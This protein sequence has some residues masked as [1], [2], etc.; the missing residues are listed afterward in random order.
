MASI[1]SSKTAGSSSP[2]TTAPQESRRQYINKSPQGANSKR[3]STLIRIIRLESLEWGSDI[4]IHIKHYVFLTLYNWTKAK[5]PTVL[6]LVN[7]SSYLLTYKVDTYKYSGTPALWIAPT[8]PV[9]IPKDNG[10]T[11][12]NQNSN[13]V[14]ALSFAPFFVALRII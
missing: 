2:L 4:E 12:I 1:G 8:L 5:D 10:R 11:L 7:S 3:E 14:I 13:R 9:T 6:S